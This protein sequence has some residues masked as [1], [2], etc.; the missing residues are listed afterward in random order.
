MSELD[1]ELNEFKVEASEL[2]E[3]AERSLLDLEQGGDFNTN[4]DSI[5]R[6]FHNLKGAFGML[7]LQE[8]G[9]QMHKLE[10][11]LTGVKAVGSMTKVQIDEFLAGVDLIRV[12]LG[13]KA[14]SDA[15]KAAP[16]DVSADRSQPAEAPAVAPSSSAVIDAGLTEFFVEAQEIVARLAADLGQL[17]KGESTAGVFERLYRDMHT[18]KGGAFLFGFKALGDFSHV[19]ESVLEVVRNNGGAWSAALL[20][21]FFEATKVIELILK[22]HGQI[23]PEVSDQ[24]ASLTSYFNIY[25]T[26][27]HLALETK[28]KPAEV[29][30]KPAPSPSSA[31]APAPAVTAESSDKE[32]NGTIRVSV[33]LLDGLMALMGEMV[34]VRNQVLQYA[35][36][37]DDLEFLNLSQRLNVVTGE[38]QGGLMKTRMQPVG[39]ILSKFSRL[40]REISKDLGKKIELVVSGSETELDKTLLEAVKDPLTHIV[41][42]SCD[43]GIETPQE[44]KQNGKSEAGVLQINSYHE[45]GHVIIEIKDNG[46]GLNRAKLIAKAIEKG[47]VK[48][49]RVSSMSD[50]E[51]INL[52]C[53]PGFSTAAQVTN[54]S[55]RGVGM[56]VVRTNIEK[57]GGAVDIQSVEGQGTSIRLQIPLTLAIVSALIVRS[58]TDHF[59]IPQLKLVE[60][61]RVDQNS[62]DA[63]VEYF[64]GE[65]VL[66]LRDRIL[67]LLDA[68]KILG[69]A[70]SSVARDVYNIV[71]LNSDGQIFGL[72]V[73]EIQD[74]ADIVVKPLAR[75]LKSLSFYS[76]ATV[77]GDGSVA[78][79]LDVAGMASTFLR[80]SNSVEASLESS[81]PQRTRTQEAQ[82]FLLFRSASNQKYAIL[83]SYVHRLEEFQRSQVEQSGENQLVR[84]RNSIL[85]LISIEKLPGATASAVSNSPVVPV[86]VIEKAGVL[87]GIEVAEILDVYTTEANLDSTISNTEGQLGFLVCETEAISVLDPFKVIQMLFLG[88]EQAPRSIGQRRIGPL[89]NNRILY[90]EDAAFFRKHVSQVLTRAGYEVVTAVD[91]QQGRAMIEGATP[92]SFGAIISDIEMPNV[93]GFQFAEF[94]RSNPAWSQV[95]LMALSTRSED[96]AIDKAIRSGFDRFLEKLNAEELVRVLGGEEKEGAA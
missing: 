42:N 76:G 48:E 22:A 38:L 50:K 91:G 94:V 27:G 60:L 17:E 95:P 23:L 9:T 37:S 92:T 4:Y 41:R 68:R 39:N 15:P 90:V 70:Q 62:T 34:L 74:T 14:A 31:A 29:Q 59:A 52:I 11:E 63:K 46:R 36:R 89:K 69:S 12:G 18:L 44:R 1:S 85:P 81:L 24:L 75:F 7:G 53:A 3:V 66:R 88:K 33:S 21:K 8:L 2:L 25:L 58:D 93:N 55:G 20:D 35:N 51:I 71:I 47:L 6:V 83:L 19:M 49:E 30:P 96:A 61:V 87:Y 26:A 5:F 80:K 77:L 40:V 67:S 32:G 43:H 16:T 45:G 56:D 79:I 73:D 54:L 65:P 10:H 13:L 72:I 57:I 86:I 28:E 64:Q 78:L 82:D 84:Y